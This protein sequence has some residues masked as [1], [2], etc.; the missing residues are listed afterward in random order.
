MALRD[1]GRMDEAIEHLKQSVSIDPKSAFGQLNLGVALYKKGQLDEA[2]GHVREAV[3]LDPNYVIAHGDLAFI[4]R[5]KGRLAESIDHLQQ[6]VRIDGEKPS[7]ARDRLILSRYEGVCV[8][9]QPAAGW[10]PEDARSVEQERAAKRSQ[11]LAWLR[12][13]LELISRMRN[14]GEVLQSSLADW[15]SD[16]ALACVR[17][18]AGLAKLPDAERESWQRLWRDVATSLAADPLEQG[19]RRPPSGNGIAHSMAMRG[20]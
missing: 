19:R 6:A 15:L 20:T 18:P 8:N 5:R 7:Q 4:L 14:N 16:S 12:A 1:R 17:D 11:A 9:V 2:F 13:N 3:T 10:C